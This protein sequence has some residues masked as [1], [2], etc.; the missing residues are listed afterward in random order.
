M[1]AARHGQVEVVNHAL[2]TSITQPNLDAVDEKG[3]T[4]LMI[5]AQEGH[6]NVVD[7]LIFAG[8]DLSLQDHSGRTAAD[9]AKTPAI[10]NAIKAGE[11][12]VESLAKIIYAQAGAS[13]S[14]SGSTS[15]GNSSATKDLFST[16]LGNIGGM[17]GIKGECPF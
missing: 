13:G 3:L 7:A 16:G 6:A 1:I 9:L 14:A 8:A 10:R 12:K 2:G 5:A 11:A 4:A 17:G 15:G